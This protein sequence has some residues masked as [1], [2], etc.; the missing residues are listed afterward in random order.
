MTPLSPQLQ[1]WLGHLTEA[2]SSLV[3]TAGSG[4]CVVTVGASHA[5]LD[6]L[7]TELTRRLVERGLNHVEVVTVVD[8]NLPRIVACE[9]EPRGR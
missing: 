7:D 5:Y 6:G 4:A 9:F 8:S 2:I 1:F 3:R